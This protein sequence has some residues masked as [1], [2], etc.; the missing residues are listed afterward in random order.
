MPIHFKFEFEKE[1]LSIEIDSFYLN[2]VSFQYAKV[3]HSQKQRSGIGRTGG[4]I[5]CACMCMCI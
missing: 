3:R 1:K 4:V 5:V 2:C